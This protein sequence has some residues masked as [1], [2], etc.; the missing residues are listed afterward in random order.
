MP[1]VS[2][3]P[4]E[5]SHGKLTIH[6]E[7]NK[8]ANSSLFI[9]GQ[10]EIEGFIQKDIFQVVTPDK[11]VTPDEILSNIKGFNSCFLII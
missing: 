2:S 5:H 10:K 3:I 11:F 7:Q 8:H 9:S 6:P 4:A 1:L